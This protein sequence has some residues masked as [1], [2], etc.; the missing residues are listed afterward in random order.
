MNC[1][2]GHL[3]S[4]S[5]V[6]VERLSVTNLNF[7]FGASGLQNYFAALRARKILSFEGYEH[8][9]LA[10]LGH[11]QLGHGKRE[12]IPAPAAYLNLARRECRVSQGPMIAERRSGWMGQAR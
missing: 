5:A 2:A 11:G 8:R 6:I 4:Q 12:Q 3:F 1:L 7:D 10:D 9:Q